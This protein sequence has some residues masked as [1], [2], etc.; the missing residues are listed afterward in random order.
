MIYNNINSPLIH[1]TKSYILKLLVIISLFQP[2]SFSCQYKYFYQSYNL[3]YKYYFLSFFL[4]LFLYLFW[5]FMAYFFLFSLLIF[6]PH[7]YPLSLWSISSIS[8]FFCVFLNNFISPSRPLFPTI[9][10]II[11]SAFS[12]ITIWFLNLWLFGFPE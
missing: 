5:H 4:I 8:N 3:F 12:V 6:W 11:S 10:S 2:Q 7:W 9:T 1:L